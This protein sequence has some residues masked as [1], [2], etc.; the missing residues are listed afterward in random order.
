MVSAVSIDGSD[1]AFL[2]AGESGTD[3]ALHFL[4]GG[5]GMGERMR[6]FDW[7]TTPLGPPASWPQSLKTIVRVMLDSRYAMWMLWGPEYTFF[8]NDAYLP[9][10]GLKRDWVLGARSDKV[11]EEVWNEAI[12]PR[13]DHVL[14]RGE[15]TWDEALQ[16][17]LERSGFAEETYHTFSYS[18]V[19][20]DGNRIAGML[21]V[22][23]EVTERV[24][25]ERRL[26]VLSELAARTSGMDSAGHACEAACEV[27][28]R[29]PL[30]VPFAALYLYDAKTRIA[31][32]AALAGI[33]AHD[34]LPATLAIDDAALTWPFAALVRGESAHEVT[35]LPARGIEIAA[36]GGADRV[37]RALVLPLRGSSHGLAGFLIAGASP[38]R[39]FDDEYRAF[40]ALVA[41][42]IAAAIGGAEAYEAERRRAEALAELDR[43]KT[44]F[45]SNV[46][47]EFRTPLTL[48]QGPLE[49][50][51]GDARLPEAL[52]ERLALAQRN[53]TRLLRLVNSLLDFSRIEAGRAQASYEPTD[54]AALT[55]DL[56]S[57]F[58]AA[59]EKA[60]LAYAVDCA[61]LHDAVHVDREMWEKI[62]L[63]L[64]SNAFKFT[65]AGRV[66]VAL[67]DDGDAALLEV[68]DTGVGVP[69]E[70]LPR[71]FERFHRVESSEGRTHEGSGI[72]LALVQELVKL[73]GGTIDAASAPG[74]GTTFRVRIPF[75]MAHLPEDRLREPIS[76]ATAL[77]AANAFVEE[78]LRWLP[79]QD[80][81]AELHAPIARDALPAAD[82]RFAATFG[83]RIVLADDNAD[84]RTYL[85]DLLAPYY[86][87]EAVADGVQ[88][89]AAARRSPPELIVS[90]VMMPRLDGFGL[91]EAVRADPALG[92]VPVVLLSARAGEEARIEGLDAGADDYIVKPFSARELLARVGA[93]VELR[94]MRQAT[95][96]ASRRRTAQFETLLNAAPLGVYLLDEALVIRAAN[97]I[98]RETFG[99][100]QD[101]IGR[102]FGEVVASDWPRPL[103]EE[104]VAVFR[105]TLATGEPHFA[106]E[107]AMQHR[108]RDAPHYFEWQA[109]RIPLPDGSFGVVCYY[110]DVSTHVRARVALEAAD[111]QKDEFLAMLAHELRNPL[112]PIRNAG[113][114]LSRLTA[115]D[116]R[117]GQAVGVVQR[118]IAGLTRL[119][120]DL[121][122]VSRITQGRIDLQSR[123]VDLREVV[124]QAVEMVEPLVREKSQ[125]LSTTTERALRVEGDPA[126]LVQCVANVL[127]NAAKYSE[128]GGRIHLEVREDDGRALVAVSDDGIGI[129]AD[130]QPHVFDLFVQGDRTLDRSQGGLGIGLSV[131]K[132]LVEMH[133]GEISV[134]SEGIGRGSRFEM[135]LPLLE[136]APLRETAAPALAVVPRR[137]LVVDDNEDA[138]NSLTLVL[139]LDGH[140]VAC[141]YTAEDALARAAAF[142]PDVA[143]LDVGLPGMSG[144][145][146]AR[147]LREMPGYERVHL[148]ALTGYGQPE[149]KAKA[150]DA[151][152][153]SHLVKPAEFRALQEILEQPRR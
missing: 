74:R 26:R 151:G 31:S 48:M 112:A 75:G 68:A 104:I 39:P 72:G 96:A 128:R 91:I 37:E 18:P 41:G 54:L 78:A 113:E 44:A 40:L 60:G 153:D 77:V 121:L 24:V 50:T 34:A 3:P 117:A 15:A 143:L 148:V 79:E 90:D 6:R 20:D 27:L 63:N 69:E 95:D 36:A 135:R 83:A 126:R 134:F 131:V 57:T 97:P 119:V 32:R 132:R 59:M 13:L 16:L 102:A 76:R 87:V 45:F 70:E 150:L 98:A 146:L 124:A 62:V 142:V 130:L 49:E 11:W 19:Y 67:R 141:A 7:T 25:G 4:A 53:T 86:L 103:V 42:Q 115:S 5:G 46:S 89:L 140:E 17:F 35:D 56:A 129:P 58:R 120:D 139:E 100:I 29:Y 80:G 51:L 105:K 137:V 94:R 28:A 106:L 38:R 125:K 127:T 66:T 82:R 10:V 81:A 14:N 111:R 1:E 21:C 30:D 147:R 55:R 88:A 109:S 108:D 149:D 122:D 84:M 133:G 61:P 138:A 136:V 107:H 22:V 123:A 73:H 23:T 52:R 2:G 43:A 93:I 116:A 99:G 33:A 101:P 12:V 152:F 71:L 145:E 8:C 64:L 114:V 47:H 85:R 118:Q 9:T 110:R 65:L 92:G 144:Y